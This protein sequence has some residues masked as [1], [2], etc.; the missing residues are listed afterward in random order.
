MIWEVAL[1]VALFVGVGGVLAIP[2]LSGIRIPAEE[3]LLKIRTH[4]W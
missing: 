2:A 1:I 3:D 4:R